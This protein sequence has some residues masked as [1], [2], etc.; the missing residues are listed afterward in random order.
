[1][2][3]SNLE[4]ASLRPVHPAYPAYRQAGAGRHA[5]QGFAR[6]DENIFLNVIARTGSDEA[7]SQW[8]S[9]DHWPRKRSIAEV[10]DSIDHIVGEK[11]RQLNQFPFLIFRKVSQRFVSADGFPLAKSFPN[12]MFV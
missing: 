2:N 6:N 7:I 10:V 8:F 11:G 4:I 12:R 3:Y 1:V 5:V 9:N